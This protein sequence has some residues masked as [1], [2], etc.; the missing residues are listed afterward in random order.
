LPRRRRL[1]RWL[2]GAAAVLVALLLGIGGFTLG[3]DLGRIVGDGAM[4]GPRAETGADHREGEA[5]HGKDAK[6]SARFTPTGATTSPSTSSLPSIACR[7][8]PSGSQTA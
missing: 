3:R 2:L 8:S 4:G 5:E 7:R 1:S 6:A